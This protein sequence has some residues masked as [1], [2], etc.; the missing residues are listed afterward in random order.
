[1]ESS[2][3]FTSSSGA[4]GFESYVVLTQTVGTQ[5]S[6]IGPLMGSRAASCLQGWFASLD[7]SGDQIV[8]VPTVATV[9][10][11]VVSGE[12]AAGFR[13]SVETRINN[14]EVQ[15]NEELVVIGA[16]RVEVGL[17]SEATGAQV[18]P[19]VESSQL[20]GLERRLRSVTAS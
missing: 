11:A 17:V 18:T 8:G 6:D 2:E 14:A 15:V 20:K 16:G 13:A 19:S 9:P 1:V 12:Q 7:R 3:W 10:V 5:V 4:L